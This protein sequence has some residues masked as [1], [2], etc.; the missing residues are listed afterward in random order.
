V[1]GGLVTDVEEVSEVVWTVVVVT[2]VGAGGV[3]RTVVIEVLVDPGFFG[4]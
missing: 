1:I 2:A 4:G 3:V